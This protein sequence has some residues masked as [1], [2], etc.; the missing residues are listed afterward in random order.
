[1]AR[2]KVQKLG[3]DEVYAE[4]VSLEEAERLMRQAYA[5]GAL[6]VNKKTGEVIDN[7]T[8]DTEEIL[9]VELLAG[10]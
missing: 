10:G 4:E 2:I 7:I 9:L 5:R 1:M 8:P 3:S 6:V